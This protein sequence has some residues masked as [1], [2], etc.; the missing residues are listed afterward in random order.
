MTEEDLGQVLSALSTSHSRKSKVCLDSRTRSSQIL[1]TGIVEL[2][3]PLNG[4]WNHRATGICCVV[5]D[6]EKRSFFIVVIDMDVR[7]LLGS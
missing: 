2:R 1:S 3:L 4:K 7:F 6:S 5:K